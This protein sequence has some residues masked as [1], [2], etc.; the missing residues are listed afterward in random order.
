MIDAREANQVTKMKEAEIEA[1]KLV[2]EQMRI[3]QYTSQTIDFCETEVNAQIHKSMH[4]GKN[5]ISIWLTVVNYDGLCQ[6]IKLEKRG[7]YA[8]GDD[9]FMPSG[10]HYHLD[11]LKEYL[12]AHGYKVSTYKHGYNWYGCGHFNGISLKIEW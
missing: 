3:L 9:S 11:T 10:P 1:T 6:E 7:A 4:E 5:H 8:N 2:E 12:V